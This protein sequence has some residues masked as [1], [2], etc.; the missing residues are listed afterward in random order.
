MPINKPLFIF[1][2]VPLFVFSF[3][4]KRKQTEITITPDALKNH[5]Q[6]A[7]IF[8][9]VNSIET[10]NY[11]YSR[12]DSSFVFV[13]NSVQYYNSDG[14]L[15]E[16]LVLDKNSDTISLLLINHLPN[17]KENYRS[18]FN[19]K[20]N[21]TLVD[22]I[23]YDKNGFKCEERHLVNDSLHYRI[24]YKT[25]GIGS[26]IEMKRFYPDYHLTNKIYY[27]NFGLVERIDEFD[28]QKKLFKYFIIEYDDSGNEVNRRAF[29]SNNEMIEFTYSQYAPNGLLLKTIYEDRI[30]NSREDKIYANHDKKGNW[31]EEIMM[32][33]KD[34]MRKKVRKIDYFE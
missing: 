8:G 22:T 18:E 33:G 17:A 30:N 10:D 26:I 28:P 5:L 9:N 29:K 6:R 16:V 2:L 19:Y 24:E 20:D 12:N 23:L 11:Y 21:Q 1:F 31:L 25:D 27:N 3:S 15:T 7:S 34:T 14:Y 32:Q 13:Y 4:C